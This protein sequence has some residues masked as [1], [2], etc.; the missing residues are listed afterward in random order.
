[1][2]K[3]RIKKGDT[4]ELISGRD[5][6]QRLENKKTIRGTVI[7]A[8]P[9]KQTV[10]VEGLNQVT[11]HTK[12]RRQ[13]ETGGIVTKDAAIRVCKVALVCKACDKTTRI[14]YKIEGD[15]KT[16]VCKHCNKEV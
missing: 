11:C 4:V 5:R 8:N 13:G 12:P 6:N 1:M 14:S 9:S 2:N 15:K 7:E 16:R 10:L 3:M